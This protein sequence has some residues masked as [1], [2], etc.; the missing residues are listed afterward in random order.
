ME[1]PRCRRIAREAS[2]VV[3]RQTNTLEIPVS[4]LFRVVDRME[5]CKAFI[6]GGTIQDQ[7][8]VHLLLLI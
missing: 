2:V 3:E 1:T 7:H 6:E 8:L 5:L 4:I